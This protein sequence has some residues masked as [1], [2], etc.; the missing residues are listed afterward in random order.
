MREGARIY[1]DLLEERRMGRKPAGSLSSIGCEVWAQMEERPP[2][3]DGCEG[4]GR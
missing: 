4:K 3:D 1:T 2:R